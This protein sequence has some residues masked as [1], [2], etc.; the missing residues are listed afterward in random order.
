MNL[1]AKI[2][3]YGFH[4][5]FIVSYNGSY[6]L[7][8]HNFRMQAEEILSDS[9]PIDSDMFQSSSLLHKFYLSNLEVTIRHFHLSSAVFILIGLDHVKSIQIR[10]HESIFQWGYAILCSSISQRLTH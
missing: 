7:L 4:Q 9:H 3:P 8:D 6:F 2:L 10:V 1:L 5:S